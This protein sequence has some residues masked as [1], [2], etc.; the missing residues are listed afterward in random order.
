M[1]QVS[2]DSRLMQKDVNESSGFVVTVSALDWWLLASVAALLYVGLVIITSASI[3]VADARSGNPFMYASRHGI[4]L[5]VALVAGIMAA[6][7]PVRV[8][9]D[10]GWLLLFSSFFLLIL[11]L[12]VGRQV[13]GSIRWIGLGP[14]N[15]QPSELA[16]LF[17]VAYIAGYLVRRSDEVSESWWGFIK[18]LAVMFVAAFLLLMEPDFGATVVIIVAVFGMIFLSGAKL[19]KFG[20]L[21]MIAAVL[22]TLLVVFQPYRFQRVTSFADP[23]ADQYGS[24]YQLTQALIAFGRGEWTGVG[25]GNSVQ[26]LMYLPEAH[27]DFVFA[28]LAEEFGLLGT[29]SVILIFASLVYRGMKIGLRSEQAGKRFSA[30]LAYGISILIGF[31]AFIN[32]GVNCGILPTKGLTLPLV[33]YGGSSL[34]VS[35]MMIG[36]LVRIDIEQKMTHGRQPNAGEDE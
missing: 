12:M 24:G 30:Y 29:V 26:K 28:I 17:L 14:I 20:V 19:T 33:S 11:V 13:N 1:S 25:L 6:R 27:T 2:L 32:I 18:P 35:C 21:L 34:I 22:G 8:W 5:C 15:F 31:Q 3:D 7:M 36:V 4:F 16:K 9:Y 10:Y 23:W